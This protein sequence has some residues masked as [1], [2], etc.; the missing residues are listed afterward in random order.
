MAIK[1]AW[2]SLSYIYL[3]FWKFQIKYFLNI[4][5]I[6][7]LFSHK[8]KLPAKMIICHHVTAK[9]LTDLPASLQSDERGGRNYSEER[10]IPK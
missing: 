7:V 1:K 10:N 9:L 3:F 2:T 4:F 5:Q 6:N 8:N